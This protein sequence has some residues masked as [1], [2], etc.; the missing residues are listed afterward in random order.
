ME[1][2]SKCSKCN[3]CWHVDLL[4]VLVASCSWQGS[5]V[6]KYPAGVESFEL[7]I[8]LDR[9][10]WHIV[11]HNDTAKRGTRAR[12]E[13]FA[14]YRRGDSARRDRTLRYTAWMIPTTCRCTRPHV[15]GR[16]AR[17]RQTWKVQTKLHIFHIVRRPLTRPAVACTAM[18]RA[19]ACRVDQGRRHRYGRYGN[20]RTS[21]VK[22]EF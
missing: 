20:G 10:H 16:T 22:D 18:A 9:E 4:P 2:A 13:R 8:V 17:T 14:S 1:L 15:Y 19:A 5:W 11:W 21:F 7:H 12:R 3:S 6:V